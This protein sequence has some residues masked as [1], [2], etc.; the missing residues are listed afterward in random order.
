[1]EEVNGAGEMGFSF[2]PQP[3]EKIIAATTRAMNVNLV[4]NETSA[5]MQNVRATDLNNIK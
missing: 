1:V 4:M 2:D 5:G 3:N